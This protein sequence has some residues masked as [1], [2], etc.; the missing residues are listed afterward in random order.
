MNAYSVEGIVQGCTPDKLFPIN[1]II[2]MTKSPN[3]RV[4]RFDAHQA[5]PCGDLNYQRQLSQKDKF[6]CPKWETSTNRRGP[7]LSWSDVCWTIKYQG[8]TAD[9][10]SRYLPAL[11]VLKPKLLLTKGTPPKH[12]QNLQCNLLIWTILSQKVWENLRVTPRFIAL[13]SRCQKTSLADS[14]SKSQNLLSLLQLP[15]QVTLLQ[16][17]CQTPGRV[18]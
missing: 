7:C 10:S 5:L 6:L 15:P 17:Q 4:I 18:P 9:P 8:W 1:L 13:E 11:A 2:N 16:S 14:R 3:T 12:C